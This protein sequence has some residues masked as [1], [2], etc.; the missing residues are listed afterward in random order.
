MIAT[1]SCSPDDF[2]ASLEDAIAD[3]RDNA[4]DR[5]AIPFLVDLIGA[6][7]PADALAKVQRRFHLLD[8]GPARL[9]Q[10][11]PAAKARKG[12]KP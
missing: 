5:P 9:R 2:R 6:K 10:Q 1:A 11:P 4:F 3:A 7:V 12:A 8:R